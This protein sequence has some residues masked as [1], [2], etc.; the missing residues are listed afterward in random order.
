ML[1]NLTSHSTPK[2][3]LTAIAMGVFL[4]TYSCLGFPPSA[5]SLF[6]VQLRGLPCPGSFPHHLF[7]ESSFPPTSC[8]EPTTQN[9]MVPCTWRIS[10][11]SVRCVVF[12]LQQDYGFLEIRD[13]VLCLLYSVQGLVE[14]WHVKWPVSFL[15][16]IPLFLVGIFLGGGFGEWIFKWHAGLAVCK[17]QENHRQK[18]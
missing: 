1:P 10:Y 6:R 12:L 7:L 16:F 11:L 18:F 8:T 2:L 9:F 15:S 14:Q 3:K 4:C 5:H 13:P 17:N